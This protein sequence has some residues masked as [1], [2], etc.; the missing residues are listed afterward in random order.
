MKTGYVVKHV[1]G[2]LLFLAILFVSAGKFYYWQGLTYLA[3]G[4]V[5]TILNYTVF[6]IDPQL[7]EERSGPHPGTK[8]WDKVILALLS[9]ATIAMYL[10]A[11]LD[12]GRYHWSL[13][14]PPILYLVGITLT[15]IGQLLFL[16]AQKQN[17]FFSS[18]VHIQ[19]DRQHTVCG[20][21]LYAFVRHPAYLGFIIQLIGFPILFAS[22]WSIIPVTVSI[23]LFIIRTELEDKT[24]RE[25]LPG[26]VEY[27]KKTR[28]KIIPG[29]W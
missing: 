5:M 24:L 13:T 15:I 16:I 25:E 23:V 6:K 20:E 1:V 12:S 7:L 8:S 27:S 4:I 11:G 2:S 28:F 21:G 3:I 26:Y 14:F 29:V 18:T 10:L 9:F 22:I 17:S 19:T